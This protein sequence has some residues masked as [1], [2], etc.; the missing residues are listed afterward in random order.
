[1]ASVKVGKVVRP[2]DATG[3]AR[4]VINAF[5]LWCAKENSWKVPRSAADIGYT[6]GGWN[7]VNKYVVEGRPRWMA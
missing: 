5:Y 6:E 1:M 4:D 2:E 7:K 3:I